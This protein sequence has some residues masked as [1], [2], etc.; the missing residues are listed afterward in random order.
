MRTAASVTHGRS[1][2]FHADRLIGRFDSHGG[3]SSARTPAIQHADTSRRVSGR[4]ERLRASEEPSSDPPS[5]MDKGRKLIELFYVKIVRSHLAP[6][7]PVSFSLDVLPTREDPWDRGA[8]VRGFW[9]CPD[10][11][12]RTLRVRTTAG[13]LDFGYIWNATGGDTP[14]V[15]AP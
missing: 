1:D 14:A 12:W 3:A 8:I 6:D 4:L 15:V 11:G 2:S 7:H 5:G 13:P 10:F 9:A